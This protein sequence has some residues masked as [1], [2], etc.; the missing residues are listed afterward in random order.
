MKLIVDQTHYYG[1]THNY[2]C[3]RAAAGMKMPYNFQ[4]LQQGPDSKNH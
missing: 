3:S 1:C 2:I 4:L